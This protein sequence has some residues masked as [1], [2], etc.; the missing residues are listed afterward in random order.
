[1]VGGSLGACA[2]LLHSSG[3]PGRAAQEV[4][5]SFTEICRPTTVL[6]SCCCV[7]VCFYFFLQWE[8]NELKKNL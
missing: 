1:M 8:T 3:A 7:L 2:Q 5:S 4:N 6:F